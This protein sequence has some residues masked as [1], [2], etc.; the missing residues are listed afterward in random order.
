MR[1]PFRRAAAA[2]PRRSGWSGTADRIYRS[3]LTALGGRVLAGAPRER[4]R[5][6]SFEVQSLELGVRHVEGAAARAGTVSSS[7]E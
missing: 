6:S 4:S 2:T 7:A 1:K 3:T 5:L